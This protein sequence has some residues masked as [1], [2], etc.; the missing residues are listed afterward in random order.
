MIR[1]YTSSDGVERED[2][3]IEGSP[4]ENITVD[5]ADGFSKVVKR[6]VIRSEG[7]QTEVSVTVSLHH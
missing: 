5:D 6:T 7:D 3:T 1:K 4:Q 2:V